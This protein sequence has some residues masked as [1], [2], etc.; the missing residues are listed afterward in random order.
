MAGEPP[1]EWGIELDVADPK[2][3][4]ADRVLNAIAAHALY[5]GDLIVIDFGTATTFDVVDYTGAYKGG[6]HR[7]RD[8]PF[9]RR[10]RRRR[11]Q[12]APGRHRGAGKHR[13]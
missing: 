8:Q 9:A 10:A 5:E 13:A 2:T 1:V 3:V 11:G 4:G 6:D 12:A 7:A